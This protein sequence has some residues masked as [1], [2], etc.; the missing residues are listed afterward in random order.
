MS[1]PLDPQ[2]L[3]VVTSAP[4]E[5]DR[6]YVLYWMIAQRRASWNA[7]L[8]HAIAHARALEKPLLV[9][10]PLD[11]D[12]RWACHRFHA[13]IIQGMCDNAKAFAENGVRYLPYVEPE[14][15][16]GRGLLQALAEHAC[17]IITDEHPS[18][19]WPALLA[20]AAER[21]DTRMEAVDGCGILPLRQAPKPYKRAVDFRR[22]VHKVFADGAPDLPLAEPLRYHPT[23]KAQIP[24]DVLEQW[25]A[26]DLDALLGPGG[27]DALPIDDSVGIVED[28]PGGTLEATQRLDR[29]L[30]RLGSYPERNHPD[31]DASSG[32]SPWLHFGHIGSAQIVAAVLDQSDWSPDKMDPDRFAKQEG[33]WGISEGAE[34]FL[35]EVITWRELSFQTAF[36]EPEDHARYEGL[37]EWARTTLAEHADDTREHIYSVEELAQ[38][39]SE[40]E[41]WNAAQR[42]LRESGVMHNYL[43]MLW[44]KRVL[45]WT[46]SPERAF[47]VLVELNNRYALD[48]RDPNSY[49]GI[50]W[51]LGRY[52]RAWGP[53]RPIYGKIRYMTSKSTLR[54]LRLNEWLER[55][56]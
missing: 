28:K 44:G 49:G 48:G 21:I 6:D 5:A 36:L 54:K 31:A 18:F 40:D 24:A 29:F 27:L 56:S 33:A 50:A 1:T 55:W 20:R 8:D 14:P 9:F 42:E 53:E 34:A 10:E 47:E 30:T 4:I 11:C 38:S 39:Q 19:R 41:L 3:R 23:T 37:P 35:E 16:Q 17:L 52:D 7:A 2:R 51:V 15:G 45:A 26:A 12:Y 43:R 32:L 25:P 22:Y 13:F 46:E